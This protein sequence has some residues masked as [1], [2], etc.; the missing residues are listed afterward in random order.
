MSTDIP[1]TVLHLQG[2]HVLAAV[3]TSGSVTADVDALTG[4]SHLAV[5]AR[6]V[7]RVIVEVPV[8]EL[9]AVQ[10]TGPQAALDLPRRYRVEDVGGPRLGGVAGAVPSCTVA[11][12]QVTIADAPANANL[13]YLAVLAT[14]DGPTVV[15]ATLSAAGGGTAASPTG[16][17]VTGALVAVE[18]RPIALARP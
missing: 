16:A 2:G 17:A 14:A 6:F 15:R 10:L 9:T 8:A 5:A 7:P 18:G 1:M 12:G 11:G 3:T 4:G 13:D